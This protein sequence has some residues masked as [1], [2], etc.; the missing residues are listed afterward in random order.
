MLVCWSCSPSLLRGAVG[1]HLVVALPLEEEDGQIQCR[2]DAPEDR[3]EAE[4]RL[5][6]HSGVLPDLE[7]ACAGRPLRERL[8]ALRM[9]ALSAAGRQAEALAA[10][11]DI[12][13]RLAVEL[14]VDPSAVL[15]EAQLAVL[16]GE[17]DRTTDRSGPTPGRLPSRLTSFVGREGE[18]TLL[19]DPAAAV[20]HQ[21]PV[22]HRHCPRS[23]C[24][25]AVTL[26][27]GCGV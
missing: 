4:L 9:R 14:G 11:E 18:S 12:R 23:S 2:G 26:S 22:R 13:G 8:A 21:R 16:P 3:F 10:Y 5:G 1:R 27:S 6:R 15:R 25:G 17:V 19:A 7:A 20:Q 24:R